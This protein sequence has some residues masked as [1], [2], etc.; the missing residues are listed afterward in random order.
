MVKPAEPQPDPDRFAAID[1]RGFLLG[2][3]GALAVTQMS[4]ASSSDRSRGAASAPSVAAAGAGARTPGEAL[5][6]PGSR[7]LIAERVY[8]KRV[9]EYLAFATTDPSSTNPVGVGAHLIR[10]AREPAYT[11]DVASVGVESFADSWDRLDNW[12]DT[13]DFDLMYL[14]WLLELGQGS[15]AATRLSPAVLDAIKQRLLANRY[16]YDDPLPADRLDNQ[17]FWSENHLLIG[18]ANEYLAGQRFPDET[19]TV[20]GLSGAKH[21]DR[22]KPDILE[23]VHDRAKLG[24]F[25]WHSNV[26]ML[27]N[28]TPLLMLVEL[29]DDPEVVTAAAMGLDLCLLDIAAHLHKGCYTAPRG[30]TYKKDKM[31]SLDEAT[32]GTAKLVFADTEAQYPSTT[33]GGATYFCAAKRY[34]PPQLLVDI[35]T[36]DKTGVVRE[37]HGVYFDGG[38]PVVPNPTAPYGRDFSKAANLPFWWSLGAIG[39]WPLA[40]V[41]VAAANKFRLW[42][43]ELFSQVKLLAALND[44]DPAKIRVWEQARSAVINFGFLSEA[45]TY[46]WRSPEVSLASVLD[47]RKGEMRDQVHAWQAAI[48]E[49]A[50]VFTT[51]PVTDID[52][53][54]DWDDDG[55]PGYWTGSASMPRSAQ[56]ERTAV[57]IYQPAWDRS[58]DPLVWSVFEYRDYTHAYV[59]QDHFDWVRQEGNWTVAE[60][61]GAYI[62]LWSWRTPTWRTY[63][64]AVY[65]TRGMVKPFDLVA[66]GGADN[67]WIVEVGTVENDRQLD[68][69]VAALRKQEPVVTRSDAGFKVRWVSPA[70]GQI[71]FGSTGPFTVK[72]KAQPLSGF[73]RHDS[74]WGTVDHLST[75]YALHAGRSRWNADFAS[76][77]RRVQ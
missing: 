48:D 2:A 42:D 9:D 37:R 64:P 25:E 75:S 23:W 8:Q 18:L 58:T 39:M 45:N 55:R 10:A 16:R 62:A 38:T 5:A 70:S 56:F 41:S 60:R 54:T 7:G 47:H 53:S 68:T 24:F 43:T 14:N 71:S 51:H 11:W 21:R 3:A 46:A 57:H 17:W 72:G 50:M 33:D 32:F 13:R 15:T 19:F 59:P 65:A 61:G 30:R 22:S 49:N 27:K 29:A 73:P 12:K 20:T 74:R 31:S 26:Y 44:F 69:V 67:V 77:T 35:A 66:E 6:K 34:R 40:D 1:R 36:S 28:I 4:C 52:K 76:L 63:D